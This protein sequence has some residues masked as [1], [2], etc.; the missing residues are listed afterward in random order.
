MSLQIVFQSALLISLVLVFMLTGERITLLLKNI[1]PN[2]EGFGV[3]AAAFI[4]I[5]IS[6]AL[7]FFVTLL[8]HWFSERRAQ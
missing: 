4:C 7:A 1:Y 2:L 3:S 6:L 5:G 8:Y